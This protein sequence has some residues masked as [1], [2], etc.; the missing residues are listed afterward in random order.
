VTDGGITYADWYLPFKYEL[1]LFYLERGAFGNLEANSY[2]S[3]KEI[4]DINAWVQDFN[5]GNQ[6]N[7]NKNDPFVTVRAVLAF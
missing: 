3:S 2:C 7:T 6:Y 5:N 1:N 4:D